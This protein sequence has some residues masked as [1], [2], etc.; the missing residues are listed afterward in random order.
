[1]D[2]DGRINESVGSSQAHPDVIKKHSTQHPAAA[3]LP[4]EAL[5]QRC[6]RD[7][8]NNGGNWKTDSM[9]WFSGEITGKPH[10]LHGK[11]MENPVKILP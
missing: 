8:T 4:Y 1:M 3:V 2:K 5:P 7:A 10:D 6:W 11:I 9:N